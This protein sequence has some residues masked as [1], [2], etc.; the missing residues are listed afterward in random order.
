[1][2]AGEAMNGRQMKAKRILTASL[3]T[4]IL[5]GGGIQLIRPDRENPPVDASKDLL[6]L[7]AAPEE[8][9][10][11]L[12]RSCYDCHSNQTRWPWYS[13]I[14]PVSWL[15]A[16]DVHEGRKHMNF[17]EWGT[18]P[19]GRQISRLEMIGTEIDKSEMPPANYLLLHRDARLSEAEK[20]TLLAW[21]DAMS[22]SLTVT[23]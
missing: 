22:D 8:I 13:A 16:D 20:D 11:I 14:A 6:T 23:P 18:Y 21:V 3:A 12:R 15:T 10:A 5:V 7:S 1:M 19:R 9:Q 2:A 4:L 17:S